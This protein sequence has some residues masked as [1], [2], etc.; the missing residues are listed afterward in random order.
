MMGLVLLHW[1][2]GCWNFGSISA[3][4]C[5][6]DPESIDSGGSSDQPEYRIRAP[7]RKTRYRYLTQGR[8]PLAAVLKNA[9]HLQGFHI[10]AG[11]VTCKI[12]RGDS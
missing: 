7:I 6:F 2:Q 10:L 5:R 3:E 9:S 1:K 8:T 11:W 4:S 12:R